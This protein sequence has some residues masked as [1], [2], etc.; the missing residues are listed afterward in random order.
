MNAKTEQGL[1]E[2]TFG[3]TDLG[4]V[5]KTTQGFEVTIIEVVP[6][7][8]AIGKT[9]KGKELKFNADRKCFGPIEGGE[10]GEEADAQ[11]VPA[12]EPAQTR[13]RDMTI[14]ELRAEYQRVIGRET[15]S[16]DRRYIM[17]KLNEAAKGRIPIGPSKRRAARDK[18]EMQVLPL[19]MA[20]TVVVKLDAAV[21]ELGYG[22]RM[23]FIRDALVACLRLGD[24][25]TAIA[26]AD[27]I[28][29]ETAS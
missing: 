18:S 7:S 14:E 15:G 11:E 10:G 3:A 2:T 21:K 17:W 24:D 9:S 27:A 16:T 20:R 8:H 25:E 26:A 22:S 13:T 28:E 4:H 5:Y 29:G 6:D 23:A 19:N 1:P 12:K